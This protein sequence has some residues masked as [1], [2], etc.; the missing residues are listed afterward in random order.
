[1]FTRAVPLFSDA[2][3]G[4]ARGQFVAGKRVSRPAMFSCLFFRLVPGGAVGVLGC[5]QPSALF[6]LFPRF[7]RDFHPSIFVL[8]SLSLSLSLCHRFST[9]PMICL[10]RQRR[11]GAVP[12]TILSPSFYA[13][14]PPH[15]PGCVLL[16]NFALSRFSLSFDVLS[17]RLEERFAARLHACEDKAQQRGTSARAG[18]L[19]RGFF[20][21]QRRVAGTRPQDSWT[22]GMVFGVGVKMRLTASNFLARR[23]NV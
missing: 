6:G 13:F 12:S 11:D 20:S 3:G 21:R 22:V 19:A 5:S 17:S 8:A 2:L 7:R 14:S 9:S 1:M 4:C 15:L 23:R 10:S 16:L 18:I